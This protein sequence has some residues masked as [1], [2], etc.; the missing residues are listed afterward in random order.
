MKF[1]SKVELMTTTSMIFLGIV[2]AIGSIIQS[3]SVFKQQDKE[4]VSR[5]VDLTQQLLKDD[6]LKIESAAEVL[7]HDPEI[8]RAF[9]AHDVTTLRRLGRASMETFDM[10]VATFVDDRGTVIPLATN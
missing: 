6:M 2:L 10:N 4:A 7:S 1:K 8:V 9:Q 3:T 5:Y